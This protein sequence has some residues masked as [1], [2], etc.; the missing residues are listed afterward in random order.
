MK[1]FLTQKLPK[2][3]LALLGVSIIGFFLY[4]KT[5]EKKVDDYFKNGGTEAIALMSDDYDSLAIGDMKIKYP[6]DYDISQEQGDKMRGEYILLKPYPQDQLI[7]GY[8]P[9]KLNGNRSNII[10]EVVKINE[11]A[12]L[13]FLRLEKNVNPTPSKVEIQ[14]IGKYD[15]HTLKIDYDNNSLYL[16]CLEAKDHI[17]RFTSHKKH[18]LNAIIR[19]IDEIETATVKNPDTLSNNNDEEQT[20]FKIVNNLKVPLYDWKIEE[21]DIPEVKV[22]QVVLQKE[23]NLIAIMSTTHDYITDLKE[24]SD[25]YNEKTVRNMK[26]TGMILKSEGIEK[27]QFKNTPSVKENFSAVYEPTGEKMKMSAITIKIKDYF[28]NIIYTVNTPSQQIID[29]I[30]IIE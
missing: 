15:V 29:N 8:E 10:E 16:Y 20:E 26:P 25:Y 23:D 3:I 1:N 21:I 17:I 18:L 7:I 6:N 22:H 4:A 13:N 28:Y 14:K 27:G 19:D 11:Q 2:I 24:Y 9:V 12:Y 30:E 5:A